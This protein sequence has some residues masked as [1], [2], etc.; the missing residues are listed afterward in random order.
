MNKY[1]QLGADAIEHDNKIYVI[2]PMIKNDTLMLYVTECERL[3]DGR[4]V[5]VYGN[6]N[7][8]VH[9]GVRIPFKKKDG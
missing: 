4:I 5:A 9:R 2:R 7:G 1:T 8:T 6:I 3:G